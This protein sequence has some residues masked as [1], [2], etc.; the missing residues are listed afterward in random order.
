MEDVVSDYANKTVTV[1]PHFHEPSLPVQASIH[2]CRH[3]AAM[4]RIVNSL[5]DSGLSREEVG[6]R[7]E[8]YL[9][10]FL[11]F[12]QSVIPTIEYDSTVDVDVKRS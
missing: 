4:K 2:P 3:S 1:E 6:G 7:V 12:V 8:L 9:I 5:I 11:K 10:Y